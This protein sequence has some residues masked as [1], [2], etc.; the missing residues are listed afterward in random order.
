MVQVEAEVAYAVQVN[1]TCSSEAAEVD[2]LGFLV[3][4]GLV[5]G[6]EFKYFSSP[7]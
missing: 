4:A 2:C 5:G 1:K 3:F 6:M 7:L